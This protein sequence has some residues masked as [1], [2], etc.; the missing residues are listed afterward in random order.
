MYV[1]SADSDLCDNVSM[2]YF[3]N[4]QYKGYKCA[5]NELVTMTC[6]SNLPHICKIIHIYTIMSMVFY[7]DID[8]NMHAVLQVVTMTC[9]DILHHTHNTLM[10]VNPDTCDTGWHIVLDTTHKLPR[11]VSG[12]G[13]SSRLSGIIS[14]S[15]GSFST[16]LDSTGSLSPA[17]VSTIDFSMVTG[18]CAGGGTSGSGCD[19]GCGVGVFGSSNTTSSFCTFNSLYK[20]GFS[21]IVTKIL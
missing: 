11:S 3:T 2:H 12:S 7:P 20:F 10:Q 1:N 18:D 17:S 14:F 21:I 4:W 15:T 9:D 19:S 8:K 6:D 16:P 13:E 5:L